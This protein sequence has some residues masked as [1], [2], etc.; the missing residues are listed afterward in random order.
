MS[1]Y[2]KTK[3]EKIAWI[4]KQTG[5]SL[6][7][8]FS[9]DF[10]TLEKMSENVI[11]DF[12]LP[13]AI[14][15]NL[16]LNNKVYQVPMVIEESSVVAACSKSFKYWNQFGGFKYKLLN[17]R[18]KGTIY[19]EKELTIDQLDKVIQSEKIQR[20]N[21]GMK[22]RNAGI[23]D[24]QLIKSKEYNKILIFFKTADAMGANYINTVL[25]EISDQLSNKIEVIMS[26]L[27][28]NYT[29]SLV[30]AWVEV[31]VDK[32]PSYNNIDGKVFL[33]KFI[34]AIKI[35]KLD[36]DRAVTHNKGIMNGVDSVLLATGND[37]RAI[38]A[39]SHALAALNGQYSSLSDAYIKNGIFYFEITLPHAVGTVG[40]NTTL[41]NIAKKSLE[42]LNIKSSKELSGVMAAVGLAQN[43]G[44]VSA[45]ITEGIQNGHM[46]LHLDNILNE[47]DLT[48]A[49]IHKIYDYFKTKKVSKYE[50]EQY[51]K[52][53]R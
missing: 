20:I 22:K 31:P 40:G 28:N 46:R 14:A 51:I 10:K 34:K 50:V 29:D 38:E 6:D 21:E 23:L 7:Y 32:I 26:I 44:A 2:K 15:P 39:S 8:E 11:G 47:Y 53:L 3:S 24:Y 5:T 18:K 52:V 35:A 13:Y 19:F 27:S 49:E 30:K 45:L 41:H 4:E 16:I 37:F 17:Q 43:F 12:P 36:P 1:F 25:E 42:I 48:D 33:S 9:V